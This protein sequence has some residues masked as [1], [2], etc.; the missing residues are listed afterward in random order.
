MK[1]ITLAVLLSA[2]AAA[3]A[4]AADFYAGIKLGQANYNYTNLT[5]NN[6]TGFGVLGGYA[7]NE[8]FAVEAE[9]VD[10]GSI[11]SPGSNAKSNVWGLS[12]IGSYPINEQ[13]SVFGKLGFA[14][15][16]IKTTVTAKKTSATYG[17]GGQYNVSPSVGVR[18]GWD[19]YKVGGAAA[20]NPA[21]VNLYS[22]AG[23]FKF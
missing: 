15:S 5:K 13:F 8:N 11:T 14:R 21:N 9:Y 19:L 23:V 12:A 3:P 17:L 10:L 20:I 6:P 22:V 4:V 18:L 2:F 1:K 7:I 16:S